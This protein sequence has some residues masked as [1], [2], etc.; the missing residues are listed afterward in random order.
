MCSLNCA[1]TNFPVGRPNLV[2]ASLFVSVCADFLQTPDRLV[3]FNTR[4][5]R[6]IEQHEGMPTAT[7]LTQI[8]FEVN[9]EFD[10]RRRAR[11]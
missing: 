11:G 3:R 4:I 8:K 6:A 2:V 1:A 9:Q 7:E 10:R 5:Q